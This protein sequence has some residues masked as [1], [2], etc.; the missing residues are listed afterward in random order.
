MNDLIL[1]FLKFGRDDIGVH[2][3]NRKLS[4]TPS[5]FSAIEG[6]REGGGGDQDALEEL[7]Y[8]CRLF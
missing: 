4:L 3:C 1:I 6:R 2:S 5:C 7:K 8:Y